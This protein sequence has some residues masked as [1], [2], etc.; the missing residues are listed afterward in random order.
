[1]TETDTMTE[2]EKEENRKRELPPNVRR[3]E[4]MVEAAERQADALVQMAR[5][6]ESFFRV[7]LK[8]P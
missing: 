5:T 4:R 7:W 1:M 2:A 3:E 8:V 6:A